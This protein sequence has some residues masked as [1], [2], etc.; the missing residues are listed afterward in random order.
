MSLFDPFL[1]CF[2]GFHTSIVSWN[3]GPS[4]ITDLRE[5]IQL[6]NNVPQGRVQTRLMTGENFQWVRLPSLLF[7]FLSP[8][9]SSPASPSLAPS[10]RTCPTGTFIS[11]PSFYSWTTHVTRG[12]TVGVV[13]VGGDLRGRQVCPTIKELEMKGR[14]KERLVFSWLIFRALC[15]PKFVRVFSLT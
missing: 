8:S 14:E 4:L 7:L 10:S 5:N 15:S 13:T 6:L 11:H 2:L 9:S 1:W 12:R 3:F